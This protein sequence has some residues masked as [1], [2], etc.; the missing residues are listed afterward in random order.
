[1]ATCAF[2]MLKV[3]PATALAP[4]NYVELHK[5]TG[6]QDAATGVGTNLI[7]LAVPT[8]FA[9]QRCAARL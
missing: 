5:V 8:A 7:R 2:A 6:I 3:N 9:R 4:R 1:M